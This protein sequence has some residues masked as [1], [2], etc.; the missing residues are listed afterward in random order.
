MVKFI[1]FDIAGKVWYINATAA[2]TVLNTQNGPYLTRVVFKYSA[3]PNNTIK[4]DNYSGA[5]T[6]Y[7]Y[8]LEAYRNAISS[9]ANSPIYD[10]TITQ[11]TQPTLN[12]IT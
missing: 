4:L 10:P 11:G 1:K 9:S 3:N 6:I 12:Q 2:N 8:I 5:Y 7:S